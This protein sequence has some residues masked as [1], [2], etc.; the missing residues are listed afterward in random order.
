MLSKLLVADPAHRLSME[1]LMRHEWFLRGLAPGALEMNEY[2]MT[3]PFSVDN[4]SA[5]G[6]QIEQLKGHFGDPVGGA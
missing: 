4:V 1:A 3:A 6:S 5:F 2:Y